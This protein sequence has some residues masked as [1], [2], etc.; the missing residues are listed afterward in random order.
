LLRRHFAA[1][2]LPTIMQKLPIE[3]AVGS[4][5][6]LN[7]DEIKA[8]ADRGDS[9]RL[10]QELMELTAHYSALYQEYLEFFECSVVAQDARGTAHL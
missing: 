9:K 8:L 3:E 6:L 4:T 10:A 1:V 5:Q 2:P 7:T